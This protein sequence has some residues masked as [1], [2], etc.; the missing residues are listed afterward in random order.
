MQSIKYY[1]TYYFLLA[2]IPIWY[3]W[4]GRYFCMDVEDLKP[5]SFWRRR[6]PEINDSLVLMSCVK[7]KSSNTHTATA[8]QNTAGWL[9]IECQDTLDFYYFGIGYN[10]VWQTAGG[11]EGGKKQFFC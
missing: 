2:I 8:L 9:Q 11:E 1:H 4:E 5:T 7:Y 3:I 6:S 10:F